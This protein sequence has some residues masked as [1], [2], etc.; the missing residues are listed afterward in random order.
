MAD[1]STRV[2]TGLRPV[3]GTSVPRCTVLNSLRNNE[4]AVARRMGATDARP[5]VG[6]GVPKTNAAH[7]RAL[8]SVT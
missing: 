6:G 8:S 3:Q 4:F 1:H 2:K 7:D 5:S